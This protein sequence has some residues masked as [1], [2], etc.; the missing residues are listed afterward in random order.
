MLFSEKGVI[1][2]L[3]IVFNFGTKL[4][5]RMEPQLTNLKMRLELSIKLECHQNWNV[6]K[7]DIPLNWNFTETGMSLN[8]EFH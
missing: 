8:L 4:A 3:G 7:T 6:T 5:V 1:T 2:F